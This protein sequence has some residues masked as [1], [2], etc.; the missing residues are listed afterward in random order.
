[1]VKIRI[2]PDN[3]KVS[4]IDYNENILEGDSHFYLNFPCSPWHLSD[5]S[6]TTFHNE[7]ILKS[8]T[9]DCIVCDKDE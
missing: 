7:C 1:M 5:D 3:T 8:F 6:N 9:L 2:D 4:S